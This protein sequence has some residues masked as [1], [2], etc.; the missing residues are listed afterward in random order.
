MG[1]LH[2]AEGRRGP[3]GEAARRQTWQAA[4]LH[5]RHARRSEH[6]FVIRGTGVVTL[7]GAEVPLETGQHVDVPCG[8]A[9]R[10]ENTGDADL[11]FIEVQHGEYC[12]ED[13]IVRL[14]DDF[15]RGPEPT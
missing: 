5:Q 12:G 3:Q 15:G 13:D 6:W 14:E 11:V 10:M 8:A 9:H 1:Q 2:G 4:E 7:D